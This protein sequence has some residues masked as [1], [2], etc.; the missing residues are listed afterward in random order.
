MNISIIFLQVLRIFDPLYSLEEILEFKAK[1]EHPQLYWFI[2][3]TL[4]YIDKNRKRC[5]T[6]LYRAFMWSE[7]EVLRKSKYANEEML[8]AVHIMLELLEE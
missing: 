6:D 5:S 1:E 8:Q 4:Y 3:L 2:A 7:L